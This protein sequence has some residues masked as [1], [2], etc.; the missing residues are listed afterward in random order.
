MSKNRISAYDLFK[1]TTR[2]ITDE[3]FLVAPASNIARTGIQTYRAYEMG[4]DGEPMRPIRLYRPPE[5]VFAPDSMRS[6]EGK[7]LTIDHPSNLVTADN[8]ADLAKGDGR[9]IRRDGN[10]MAADITMRDKDAIAAY[11]AGKKELSNGYTF[12]LDMTPGVSPEDGQAYD[13]VQRNIRGNHIALVDAARCG[14]ACRISDSNPTF[15]Q[16]EIMTTTQK[17]TVDGIPLEVGDTAAAVINRLVAERDRA[18]AALDATKTHIT[19]QAHTAAMAAKDAEIDARKKDVMTPAARD[20]MVADW[21]NT[22]VEAKRLVPGIV[23][24]GKTCLAVRRE[25]LATL[26]GKD[27]Q[28]KLIAN[29]VLAGKAVADADPDTVRAAFN[30]VAASIT[31]VASTQQVSGQD[32]QLGKALTGQDAAGAKDAELSGRE[33]MMQRQANAWNGAAAAK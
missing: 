4:L 6:F 7:P 11:E 14:S 3:G 33:K 24:D 5:E 1:V 27:G 16:E 8:W 31:T 15:K 26:A 22:L 30:A 17:I 29:A 10:Y 28:P 32:A 21:S 2:T 12:D 19:A 23:T 18:T 13:G 9:N 25:V 20:A